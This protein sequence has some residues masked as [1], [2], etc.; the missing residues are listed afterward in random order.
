MKLVLIFLSFI[1]SIFIAV[2]STG[3]YCVLSEAKAYSDNH[4]DQYNEVVEING[5]DAYFGEAGCEFID[6]Y[7]E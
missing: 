5:Y 3:A 2:F 4:V 7:Y 6:G 1:F